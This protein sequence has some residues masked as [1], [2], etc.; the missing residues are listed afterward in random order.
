MRQ[1]L[2]NKSRSFLYTTA[3]PPASAGAALGAL[4]VIGS[5]TEAGT[6]LLNRALFFRNRLKMAGLDT[7]A[8]A[9]QIVPVVTG[10]SS[11]A[12][13]LSHSLE[14]KNILAVAIRPPTVPEGTARLRFSITLNHS[15]ETLEKTVEEVTELKW[16]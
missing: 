2:I 14:N 16:N 15:L 6:V 8:S 9:S 5:S 7:G 4:E 12:V 11:S 1:F 13:A 3:L 10:K